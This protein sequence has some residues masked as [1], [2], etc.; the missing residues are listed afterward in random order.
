M[1]LDL[2][3]DDALL[4]EGLAREVINRVQKLRKTSKLVVSDAID[5]YMDAPVGGGAEQLL[6]ALATQT[7][8]IAEVG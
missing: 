5:V 8:A 6:K 3:T 7:A 1:V 2:T 4:E